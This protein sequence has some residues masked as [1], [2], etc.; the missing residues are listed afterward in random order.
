MRAGRRLVHGLGPADAT[1]LIGVLRGDSA[2]PPLPTPT[3]AA[4]TEDDERARLQALNE[5]SGLYAFEASAAR[6]SGR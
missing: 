4:L 3:P 5:P 1:E 6:G 2:M